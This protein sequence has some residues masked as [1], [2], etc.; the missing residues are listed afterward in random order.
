MTKYKKIKAFETSFYT[1]YRMTDTSI[2][3]FWQCLSRVSKTRYT[4]YSGQNYIQIT[5]NATNLANGLAAQTSHFHR[6]CTKLAWCSFPG[7]PYSE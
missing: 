5:P 6:P 2:L 4:R 3:D 7:Q 1:N